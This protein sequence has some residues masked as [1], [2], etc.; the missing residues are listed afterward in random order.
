MRYPRRPRSW[1]L[2]GQDMPTVD[3]A[4]YAYVGWLSLPTLGLDLPIM[5]SWDGD[6]EALKVAPCRQFGTAADGDLVI[7]GHNYT[8]HFGG[9]RGLA[10]GDAV[11][12]VDVEGH[13]YL[14][15]VAPTEVVAPDAVDYV[16]A[17]S[18]DLTL[19]TCTYGGGQRVVVRCKRA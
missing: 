9:L 13:A 4:G 1:Q 17:S 11:T 15:E 16:R 10:V 18:W 6:Y 12:F 3:I 2:G 7:A 14:Y 5:A 19:Y 8:S